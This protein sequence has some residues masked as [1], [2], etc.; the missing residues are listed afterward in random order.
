MTAVRPPYRPFDEKTD[1]DD[2]SLWQVLG[3]L[4][5]K[6]E[7]V[8]ALLGK[9]HGGAFDTA[10]KAAAQQPWWRLVPRERDARDVRNPPVYEVELDDQNRWIVSASRPTRQNDV[11]LDWL[12]ENLRDTTAS[13]NP[14]EGRSS[15]RSAG[16]TDEERKA[17][18]ASLEKIERYMRE[19]RTELEYLDEKG[20]TSTYHYANLHARL[21]NGMHR[22][23]ALPIVLAV[24]REFK[25]PDGERKTLETV[26]ADMQR[27]SVRAPSRSSD[28]GAYRKKV[29][30]LIEDYEVAFIHAERRFSAPQVCTK[31]ECH[32]AG[33]F[34]VVNAGGFDATTMKLA[35]DLTAEAAKLVTTAGFPEVC[36][37]DAYVTQKVSRENVLAFY[38]SEEDRMYVRAKP[39]KGEAA[40][41]VE[42]IVHELG[43]RLHRKFAHKTADRVMRQVHHDWAQRFAR[44]PVNAAEYDPR[45]GDL[46]EQGKRR[47]VVVTV[48]APGPYQAVIFRRVLANGT[49]DPKYLP[50]SMLKSKLA[51]ALGEGRRTDDPFPSPYA[52]TS[53]TEMFAELFRSV[54][55]G[56]ATAEQRAAFKQIWEAR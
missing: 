54:A 24:L 37:G 14:D 55:V 20:L 8:V 40:A 4:T 22:D 21:V 45:P 36:Y 34:R 6:P 50:S 18:L 43:H 27:K 28:P 39:K 2:S 19:M 23:K 33:C 47:Y 46:F 10:H 42:T 44:S 52:M 53:P 16:T 26:A 56:T 7:R 25:L 49:P 15:G 35:S 12:L 17:Y 41:A 30:N 3:V 29:A 5:A 31:N 1:D 9:P 48:G 11:F 38:M 13:F 51:L 32:T